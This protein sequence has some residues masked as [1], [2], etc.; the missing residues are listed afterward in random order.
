MQEVTEK[1]DNG[2]KLEGMSILAVVNSEWE[3]FLKEIGLELSGQKEWQ[4]L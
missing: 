1:V 4:T 3:D 2:M